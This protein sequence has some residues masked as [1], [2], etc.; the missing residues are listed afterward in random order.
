M[1]VLVLESHPGV[2]HDAELALAERGHAIVRCDTTDRRYPCRGLAFGGECPLDRHVDVAVLAQEL[3]TS[4]I[5]H[6][7]LCAARARVPVVELGTIR[8]AQ[9]RPL[10]M[11]SYS[12]ADNLLGECERA[13]RD[14]SAHGEAVVGRLLETGVVWP[15][16]VARGI[17]D[18]TVDR[19]EN[20]L[21][22]TIELSGSARSRRGEIVRAATEALRDFDTRA[23]VIDIAV[24]LLP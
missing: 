23:A 10:S 18:V 12:T 19:G 8:P 16:E 20:R 5:E 7:A 21:L 22:M 11:W 4:H 13:A 3:G 6:G 24:R 2:A 17:V 1:K 9:R 15:V 14:G